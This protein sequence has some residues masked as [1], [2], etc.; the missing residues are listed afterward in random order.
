MT[1]SY[2]ETLS[3]GIFLLLEQTCAV[4]FSLEYFQGVIYLHTSYNSEVHSQ[5]KWGFFPLTFYYNIF[6]FV[7]LNWNKKLTHYF[8]CG[9]YKE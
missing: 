8:R 4:F 6:S 2:T 5:F 3:S 1:Q 9:Q 7:V